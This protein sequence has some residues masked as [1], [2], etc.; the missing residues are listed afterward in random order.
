LCF[1]VVFCTS[2]SFIS[3]IFPTS[4]MIMMVV[5]VVVTVAAAVAVIVEINYLH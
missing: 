1:F 2:L 5:V 3:T 4:C